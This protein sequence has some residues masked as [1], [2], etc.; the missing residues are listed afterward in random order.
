MRVPNMVQNDTLGLWSGR[1]EGDLPVGGEQL[2]IERVFHDEKAVVL[3]LSFDQDPLEV[4]GRTPDEVVGD[5]PARSGDDL[6]D[7]G[8]YLDVGPWAHHVF[9]VTTT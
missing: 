4:L 5:G 9:A 2:G 8:L 7:R 3:D 1:A 6:C